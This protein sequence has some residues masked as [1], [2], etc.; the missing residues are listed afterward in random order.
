MKNVIVLILV[1]STTCCLGQRVK[2]SIQNFLGEEN[3]SVSQHIF[4]FDTLGRKT[5]EFLTGNEDSLEI[6]YQNTF[7]YDQKNRLKMMI[8]EQEE[9]FLYT[10]YYYDKN[11]LLYKSTLSDSD[12]K[13]ISY[14]MYK[15]NQ[16]TYFLLGPDKKPEKS[17]T[18]IVDSLG[19]AIRSFGWEKIHERKQNW[20]YKYVNEYTQDKKL[21]KAAFSIG[22]Q[23]YE[24]STFEYD[25]LGLIVKEVKTPVNGKPYIAR[26]FRYDYY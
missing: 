11:N 9:E 15:K 20:D 8:H 23:L 10:I 7:Y 2:R 24:T 13:I 14:V 1:L 16:S 22:K 18:E 12:E 3:T 26:R 4:E 5:K 25:S 17:Q 19:N 21:F 6:L